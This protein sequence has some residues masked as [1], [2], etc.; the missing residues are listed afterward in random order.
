MT[1]RPQPIRHHHLTQEQR[2]SIAA[3]RESGKSRRAIALQL[4]VAHT[5]ISREIRRFNAPQYAP[6][7]AHE[8][9]IARRAESKKANR[10]VIGEVKNTVDRLLQEHLSPEQISG[11][12]RNEHPSLFIGRMTVYRYIA[13]NRA[14]GGVLFKQLRHKGKR[15]KYGKHKSGRGVIPD[16]RDI[17]ERPPEVESKKRIG[18][19]ELDTIVGAQHKGAI[20]SIVDRKSKKVLLKKVKSRESEVVADAIIELLKPYSGQNKI[21]TMTADNGKEFALHL[22]ISAALKADFFFARPYHSWERGLNEHT[23]GLVREFFPKKTLFADITDEDVATVERILN[24]RPRKVLN[25]MTPDEVF[26][27]S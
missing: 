10:K 22:K 20:V 6:D 1:H 11:F 13:Q 8:N 23:N 26:F 9:A 16:R 15:Y 7:V 21:H 14:S 25:F 4:K 2:Y 3:L 5:T 17:S 24:N 19:W 18:D 12:L 27:A